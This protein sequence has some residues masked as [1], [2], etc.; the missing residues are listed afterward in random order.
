MADLGIFLAPISGPNPSGVELR[1]DAR[2]HA[3]ERLLE[4][5]SRSERQAKVD[6]GGGGVVNVDWS[7]I[8][9][10]SAELATQGRDL[11]LLVIVARALANAQGFA[12][13]VE[14][15]DLLTRTVTDHWD[16][17]HPAL[18]DNPA[19]KEAAIRRTNA[20]AQLENA[21]NGLRCDLEFTP[22]MTLRI[23]GTIT[24]GDLADGILT[25]S[26]VLALAP[27][28]SER[29]KPALLATHE[30]RAN[31]VRSGVKAYASEQPQA[32]SDL[33]AAVTL[34]QK[35]LTGLEAAIGAR[36]SDDGVGMKFEKLSG[37]L[38]RILQTLNATQDSTGEHAAQAAE[39]TT[40]A[41][42]PAMSMNGA[43]PLANGQMMGGGAGLPGR[44]A[45][46]QDV[47]RCLDMIIDFYERTEPSSPIPH[48]AQRMRKMV[49]MNFVQLMEEIAP[50]GMKEF[51]NLAGSTDAKSQ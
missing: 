39:G 18:R 32:M 30:A 31:R 42:D 35:S 23:V 43:T 49:P 25:A 38:G 22:V 9:D 16:N 51:R 3:I 13:L 36:V 14:G 11:R 44:V 6:Q 1:N 5:T 45:S 8:V 28:I 24:C 27:G 10:Q 48:L 19:P 20:M 29:E 47:M 2:F 21:D 4:P 41:N 40:M 15:L 34:A 26:Q 46:R 37:F 50:S 17:L 7:G 33:I 12:G